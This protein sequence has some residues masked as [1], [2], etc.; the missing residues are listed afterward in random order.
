M[1]QKGFHHSAESVA[2]MI[3]NHRS[4]KGYIFPEETKR[5][6]SLSHM[7]KP[8]WNK[9]MKTGPM[10][11]ESRAKMSASG[12]GR[13]FS[14]EHK[15]RISEALKGRRQP[16]GTNSPHWKNGKAYDPRGYVRVI[17]PNHPHA[18]KHGYVY[19]HRLIAEKMLGRFLDPSEIV[20][21]INKDK[22]DSH[23]NNLMVLRTDSA[24]KLIDKGR[25]IKESDIIFDGRLL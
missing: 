15:K 9:G 4:K 17:S 23:P 19:E 11:D 6:I 21:H 5:K 14:A 3:A 10:S 8:A 16:K 25:P 18:N 24:H 2:K 13:K 1:V 12:K 20:H 7:G 22:S